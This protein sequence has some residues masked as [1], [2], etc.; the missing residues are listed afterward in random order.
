MD[1]ISI[2]AVHSQGWLGSTGSLRVDISRLDFVPMQSNL[3]GGRAPF[4]IPHEEVTSV[5][6]APRKFFPPGFN[7]Q[8]FRRLRIDSSRSGTHYFAVRKADAVVTA[9]R[10]LWG[11]S[12]DR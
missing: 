10:A 7:G 6:L 8:Y 4:T 11:L 9:V 5:A 12:V 2:A 3:K 1:P